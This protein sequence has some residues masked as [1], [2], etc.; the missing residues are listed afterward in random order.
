[1]DSGIYMQSRIEKSIARLL[2]VKLASECGEVL[3]LYRAKRDGWIKMP[4]EFEQARKNSGLGD[5]Y[6]IAYEEEPRILSCLIK[7]FF[8]GEAIK[9]FRQFNDDLVAL[10]ENEKIEFMD[11]CFNDFLSDES[12]HFFEEIFHATEEEREAASLRFEAL[13]EDEKQSA[14][15][16]VQLLF[17]FIYAYFYNHIALMVH[18]QKL[19][20]LVPLAMQGDKKAFCKAI[21]ID[22]NILT[23]HP[24]FRDTYA[25]LQTGEDPNFLDGVTSYIKRPP[26]RGRIRFPALYM[27]FAILDGFKRLEDFTASEILDICD[28]AKLDRYQNRI[29][30]ECNLNKMRIEYRKNQKIGF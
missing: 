26:I 12:S 17:A 21:Q 11:L 4:E 5:L 23:G 15:I 30:D 25:R 1:M 14:F 24:Y 18:G 13:P 19:T 2:A 29:E 28:D 16:T 3:S 6:V 9:E 22:R 7:S 20:T 27:L 10:P 8:P